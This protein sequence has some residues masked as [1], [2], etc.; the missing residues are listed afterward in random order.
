[1][2]QKKNAEGRGGGRVVLSQAAVYVYLY[3]YL[4]V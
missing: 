1:M 2:D 4:Y 3:V